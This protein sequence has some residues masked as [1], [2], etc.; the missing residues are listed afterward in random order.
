MMKIP[1]PLK[2]GWIWAGVT[3]DKIFSTLKI[4]E[5]FGLLAIL[6]AMFICISYC[7][8]SIDE[9]QGYKAAAIR[10]F[11]MMF[12]VANISASNVH[13]I[14]IKLKMLIFLII[15]LLGG[16]VLISAMVGRMSKIR[17]CEYRLS[18]WPFSEKWP[19]LVAPHIVVFGWNDAVLSFLRDGRKYD[20]RLVFILTAVDPRLIHTAMDELDG[21]WKSNY[22]IYHC[23]YDDTSERK[24]NL[25]MNSRWMSHI[26]I[27]GDGQRSENDTRS[28]LLANT[29]RGSDTLRGCADK[30]TNITC[31]IHD[32]GLAYKMRNEND[33]INIEN[34]HWSWGERIAAELGEEDRP[35][36]IVGFGAMG[37]AIAMN[38]KNRS[39][40]IVSAADEK[41]LKE[42]VERFR[43]EFPDKAARV[44][45]VDWDVFCALTVE[46]G[47]KDVVVAMRQAEKGMLVMS[48]LIESASAESRKGSRYFLS[49][50]IDGFGHENGLP[51]ITIGGQSVTLFGMNRGAKWNG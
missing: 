14:G 20:G 15:W 24:K 1:M 38:A 51:T 48:E 42:E 19:W 36:Y 43:R 27:A 18:R 46:P 8:Y 41:K 16:G 29:L 50:E 11:S 47:K 37:K 12:D 17:D 33:S 49:Q 31:N 23:E 34:F 4:F 22:L 30:K 39:S 2:R 26:Y 40:I 21:L 3:V 45:S 9:T 6:A 28:M 32:F 13:T 10:A 35:I 44:E 7:Y 25:K 5:V